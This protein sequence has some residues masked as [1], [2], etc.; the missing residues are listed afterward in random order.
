M[1]EGDGAQ[2]DM[3]VQ[4]ARELLLSSRGD[5][6]LLEQQGNTVGTPVLERLIRIFHSIDSL[7][8]FFKLHHISALLERME[9]ILGLWKEQPYLIEASSMSAVTAA[10]WLLDRSFTMDVSQDDEPAF[11][12]QANVLQTVL[13]NTT[14]KG[15]QK[16]LGTTPPFDLHD[17]PKDVAVAVAEGRHMFALHFPLPKTEQQRQLSQ[18]M[19]QLISVGE[20]VTSVPGIGEHFELPNRSKSFSVWLLFSTH[21]R[22]DLL[23]DLT[24]LSS[25]N[26][27]PL[28]LPEMM[29]VAQVT[30][31]AVK[32][33]R[34]K[35]FTELVLQTLKSHLEKLAP[36]PRAA[37]P[38]PEPEASFEERKAEMEL[39]ALHLGSNL[40]EEERSY[41]YLKKPFLSFSLSLGIVILLAWSWNRFGASHDEVET[42]TPPLPDQALVSKTAESLP[43]VATIVVPEKVTNLVP[44]DE[45][46]LT[47]TA[48]NGENRVTPVPVVPET[49]TATPPEK[50][51]NH[52][53]DSQPFTVASVSTP[54]KIEI[55]Q[56]PIDPSP[57]AL[58]H[59]ETPTPL[60]E[61]EKPK[62]EE[63]PNSPETAPT[64]TLKVED[65][66]TQA[67]IPVVSE[68]TVPVMAPSKP[69][70]S[71]PEVALTSPP[72]KVEQPPTVK[73]PPPANLAPNEQTGYLTPISRETATVYTTIIPPEDVS[74]GRLRFAR[75]CNGSVTFSISTLLNQTISGKGGRLTISQ[76]TLQG[77]KLLLQNSKNV[78]GKALTF[79]FDSTGQVT[80]S[81][82]V[83]EAFVENN[84]GVIRLSHLFDHKGSVSKIRDITMLTT[85][86]V[87][88]KM[89][90]QREGTCPK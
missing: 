58:A 26:L 39:L 85:K 67:P 61:E 69:S 37:P 38:A 24:N 84:S 75:N 77:I 78:R 80:I 5:L 82:I 15:A 43:E 8:N 27:I 33:P 32:Q 1:F 46:I 21:L 72:P 16:Y 22:Q 31:D 53:E 87:L 76:D 44:A 65:S 74:K 41:A 7:S 79:D 64:N 12:E 13:D 50:P 59:T 14:W 52:L 11:Q 9:S 48:P 20:L 63:Q 10:F 83:W 88:K 54:E 89:G 18:L 28:P 51:L 49:T 6:R 45:P 73:N 3:F 71:S 19:E 4:Q 17:Y 30:A 34:E 68:N 2:W 35:K 47:S 36:A 42:L 81:P 60:A 66:A 55:P 23:M 56:T 40:Q 29:K 86:N 25:E 57:V 90:E 70:E 62:P